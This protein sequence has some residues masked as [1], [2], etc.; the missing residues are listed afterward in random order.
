[1]NLAKAIEQYIDRD[2][3]FQNEVILM[4]D[5]THGNKPYIHTWNI[6]EKSKPTLKKLQEV[7]D[8]TKKTKRELQKEKEKKIS[9]KMRIMAGENL[10]YDMAD[11][12]EKLSRV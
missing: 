5:G 6:K 2:V 7:Y 11:E 3:D 1:M 4:R 8:D 10:G 9:L 12:T